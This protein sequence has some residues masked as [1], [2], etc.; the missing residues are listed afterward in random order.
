MTTIRTGISTGTGSG[1]SHVNLSRGE[2]GTNTMAA[3]PARGAGNVGE[4]RM[5]FSRHSG[6]C[7][8]QGNLRVM[9]GISHAGQK[10]NTESQEDDL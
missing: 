5:R 8:T 2:K 6:T 1:T 10:R 3:S 7:C 9:D 4:R